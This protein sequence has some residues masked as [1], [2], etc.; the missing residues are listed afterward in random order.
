M[1]RPA[2]GVVGAGRVGSALAAR[3]RRA[4]YPIV[5]VSARSPASRLRAS[6]VLPG[7]EV[8]EPAEVAQ[9]ADLLMLAVPDDALADVA[10]ALAPSIRPGTVVLHTSG[11]H[12]VAPLAGL[13]A[14]GARVV[15]FHP[16]MTFTGTA[17]DGRRSCV[18]GLTAAATE[19]AVAEELVAALDGTPLWI[20]EEDR[21][22][23]HAALAHAA[24]HL[25]TVVAQSMEVLRDIGGHAGDPA[26]VLRPLLEAALT[27]TLAYGDAALT[28]PVA[29]GDAETVRAHAEALLDAPASTRDTYL[30][31]A[32]ATT[33][34][35]LADDQLD[36][37]AAH[38]VRRALREA[39]GE[40]LTATATVD[41]DER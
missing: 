33:T 13:E 15:A 29:R 4:G 9:R 37:E 17:E 32:R 24:N 14:A 40:T 41:R 31:L 16:A 28:G 34:R 25:V 23:Y 6:T 39:D 38:R 2:V 5:A 11:R 35:A 7:V 22:A 12:G 21:V 26:D 20:A 10:T 18:V 1:T 3:L 27:N 8:L 19:R 30:A 36:S